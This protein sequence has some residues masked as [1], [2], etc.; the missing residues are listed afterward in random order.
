MMNAS[1]YLVNSSYE[2]TIKALQLTC[3]YNNLSLFDKKFYHYENN[4]IW[5]YFYKIWQFWLF[6]T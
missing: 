4:K 6:F 1:I 5:R 2:R 3:V